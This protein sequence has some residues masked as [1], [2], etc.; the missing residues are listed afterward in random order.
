MSKVIRVRY[1][2]GVLKPLDSVEFRE[3]EELLVKIIEVERR[4]RVLRKYRGVLGPA[5]KELLD[6][7]MLEAEEQ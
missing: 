2:K 6:R 7:F 3:G 4:R 1:E 5:P